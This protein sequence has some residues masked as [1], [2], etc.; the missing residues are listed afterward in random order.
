MATTLSKGYIL[1]EDGD[2]GSIWFP[3]LEDDIQRLNDHNHNGTNSETLAPA[4]VAAQSVT[5]AAADWGVAT[6]G[7]YTQTKTLPT[8][9]LHSNSIF[10]TRLA[11]GDR[12]YLDV[13]KVSNTSISVK[14]NDNSQDVLV[15]IK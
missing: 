13:I 12:A 5:C 14:T 6:N 7:I 2:P 4:A 1:P 15:L 10:E 9:I 11:N 8:D 3:A